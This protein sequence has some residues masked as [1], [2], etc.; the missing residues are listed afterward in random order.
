LTR[1][2]EIAEITITTSIRPVR[3][4]EEPEGGA[5]VVVVVERVVCEL[6]EVVVTV[7]TVC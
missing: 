2:S 6:V 4:I 7:V 5:F 1:N 3:G